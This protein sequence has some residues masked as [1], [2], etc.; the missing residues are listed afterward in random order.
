MK[1][2][3]IWSLAAMA[4]K[5]NAATFTKTRE[6]GGVQ[7][8]DTP[9]VR[10]A[11]AYAKDTSTE[12]VFGHIMRSWL[13][14]VLLVQANED[15]S[16]TVDLE[17]H[18]VAALLHDLGWDQTPGSPIISS[19]RRFEVDGAVAAKNFIEG[20]E[21]GASWDE[22]RVQLVWDAIAL[23]GIPSIANYKEIDVQVVHKGISM[24]WFGPILGVSQEDYSK[25][26]AAFPKDNLMD[27]VNDAISWL[28]R[29][30]PTTTYGKLRF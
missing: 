16:T 10:A 1:S 23:H 4:T 19:D 13:Y 21:Y 14:G 30:K 25:V 7:V 28:C 27:G 22:R 9:L 20:N 15:L 2:A 5:S 6:I 18:A 29:T 11:E 26:S 8:I 3:F 17:T 24:E 12:L